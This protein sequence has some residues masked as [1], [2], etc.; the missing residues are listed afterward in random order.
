MQERSVRVR[1]AIVADRSAH[2]TAK[3]ATISELEGAIE[4]ITMRMDTARKQCEKER[5]ILTNR[6]P[7]CNLPPR[8]AS[9]PTAK[10]QSRSGAMLSSGVGGGREPRSR[11]LPVAGLCDFHTSFKGS[12][13]IR[14]VLRQ[15]SVLD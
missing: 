12:S 2:D 9:T 10:Q 14:H 3:Q 13:S 5:P 11:K 6:R 7:C 8:G 4:T 1:R 15:G